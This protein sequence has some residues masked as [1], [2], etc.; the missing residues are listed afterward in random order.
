MPIFFLNIRNGFGFAP[1]EEGHDLPTPQDAKEEAVKGARSLLGSE[2]VE[3]RLDL[4]GRIEVADAS[5]K[6]IDIVRFSDVVDI[7]TGELP[8]PGEE[9]GE[10]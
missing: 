5:G 8:D 3:G 9:E 4:R 2:L 7:L 10:A 6:L 1:D